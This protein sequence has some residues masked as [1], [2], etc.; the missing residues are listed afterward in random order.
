MTYYNRHSSPHSEDTLFVANMDRIQFGTEEFIR[1]DSE[2][3]PRIDVIAGG[4]DISSATSQVSVYPG[5]Q[6][7]PGSA[8]HKMTRIGGTSMAA[9]QVTGVGA[10]WLQA[11]PGGTAQQFKDFLKIH[12]TENS[13][14]SG[15]DDSFNTGNTTPRR[16]GAPNKILHWPYNSP[17]PWGWKGTSGSGT[18]GINT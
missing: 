17:N 10:L 14:D 7:Y 5:T 9:P 1:G 15:A 13:Y 4:D 12:A 3:G 8:T 2:R 6:F 16:Y 18:A 11:N